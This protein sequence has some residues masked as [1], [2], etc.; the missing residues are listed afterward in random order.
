MDA[1]EWGTYTFG[2]LVGLGV[3]ME[4]SSGARTSKWIAL[5][6]I[7][8]SLLALFVVLEVAARA[9]LLWGDDADRFLSY[10]S[11]RQIKAHLEKAAE[12][13][14][15]SPH[16]YLGYTPAPNYRANENRHNALGFRD[17]E[18]ELP[19][20]AHEF[21][22]V[23][24]GGSTTYTP[25]VGHYKYSYPNVIE[26]VLH[27][28]GYEHVNVINAGVD[29]WTSHETLISFTMRLLELD[30]DLIIV[31]HSINDV[32]AR[33]VWP[34]EAY[35]P[36]NSGHRKRTL[37]QNIMPG[38]LEHSTLLRGLLIKLGKVESHS[39]ATVGLDLKS[40][41]TFYGIE[42]ERQRAIGAYPAG[43]FTKADLSR[44]LEENSVEHFATNIEHFVVLAQH[45]GIGVML[46]TPA[47]TP[48]F[49]PNSSPRLRPLV[50]APEF[51]DA[52]REA[53]EILRTIAERHGER[54]FDFE[55]VFPKQE[56]LFRDGIHMTY[57]G[58]EVKGR[59]FAD[60][61]LDEGIIPES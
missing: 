23:C 13:F 8:G 29:G 49:D 34:P 55:A 2:G 30:A 1:V 11:L 9:V 28:R 56:T 18:I 61:L 52:C 32:F 45:H 58:V 47:F 39:A 20:P 31:H 5:A 7:A 42:F 50:T 44:M 16:Y 27:E 48:V 54:F 22:I 15:Y 53:G 10:A 57:E 41:D 33:I 25:A 46:S 24:V 43:V 26:R 14:K 38:I 37:T 17:D 4:D 40:S 3:A 51:I 60:H 35:R 59:I 36:D 12:Y 6:M 19:K 21:R